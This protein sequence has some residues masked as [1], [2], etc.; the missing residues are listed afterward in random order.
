MLLVADL[1]ATKT[2]VAVLASGSGPRE[3]LT[4][5]RFHSA[6]Y[7]RFADIVREF[8]AQLGAPVTHAC[9]DVAGPVVDGCAHL[10]NLP[11]DINARALRQ[12]LGLEGI[13]VINDLAAIAH[14]IPLLH[15]DDLHTLNAGTPV[16][17]GAIAVIAPGTGLGEAFLVWDGSMYCS[18]PSEGGHADFAPTTATQV[19]L[20]RYLQQRF[21]HVSYELACSGRGISHLYDFCRDSRLAPESSELAA[22]LTAA[23]DRTPLIV[24]GA[25][26]DGVPDAL[27]AA[28]LEVFV[29]VLGAE[30][31]NLALKVLATGGIFIGGGIVPRILPIL[32]EGHFV[33]AFRRK[34]RFAELLSRVPIHIITAADAPLIGAASYGLARIGGNAKAMTGKEHFDGAA[35]NRE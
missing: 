16:E 24:A 10:T 4:R 31:G 20:L 19:D 18:Y 23:V 11:W 14:S 1:G 6:D 9:F 21:E 3:F 17:G 34:G 2:D 7:R 30:A 26:R 15:S 33:E 5:H 27:C 35:Q 8:L 12:D 32:E 13:W 25:T 29:T 22:K 28:T